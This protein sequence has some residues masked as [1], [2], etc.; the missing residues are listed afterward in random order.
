M[1]T[2]GRKLLAVFTAVL[3]GL[4]LVSCTSGAPSKNDIQLSEVM[5]KNN[6]TLA[7]NDNEYP[8][9]IELY[10]PTD[11]EISLEGYSLTDNAKKKG[12]FV[13]PDITMQPGEYFVVYA[14]GKDYVDVDKRIIHLPYSINSDREDVYLYN[15]KGKE[16][17]H[18]AL[19]NLK[20]NM[21]CGL[22]EKG[23]TVY[24]QTPTPGAANSETYTPPQAGSNTPASDIKVYINEYST[25]S[26]VTLADEDGEFV[27]WVELYNYGDSPVNLSGCTLSDDTGKTDKWFFPAVTIPAGGYQVVYLSGKTKMYTE[28]GELHADFSLTGKESIIALYGGDGKEVDSCPVYELTSNLTYGRT[29]ADPERLQ[30]FAKATPGAANTLPGFDEIDSARYPKN[31]DVI[32]S[33]V[34]AVNTSGP[35]ASDKQ[36]YDYIELHNPTDKPVSLNGYRLSDKQDPSQWLALPDITLEPGAYQVI[37]CADAG[38]YNAQTKEIFLKLGL[39]RYGEH[40]YLTDSQGVV[41]DSFQSGRLEDTYSCGRVSDTDPTVYFFTTMTPGQANPTAGLKGP[42]PTPVFSVSTGYVSSGTQVSI[43]CPGAVIRYTTDGSTPTADSPV[44]NGPLTVSENITIRARAYMDGRLPS[45]DSS[46]SYLIGRKHDMPVIF[47]STDPDNLFD[48]NTG[49][50]A[51]GPGKSDTFPFTGANYWKDWERPVHFE[52]MDEKGNAQLSFNAGIKVFGQYSR[53]LD[54]KSVSIN[55]RDK[56]GPKEICYPFFRDGE[57]NV[58]SSLVLRDS[59]QDNTSAH[60]RDAFCAMAVKGQMDIDIMDYRP[61]VVYINGEYYG[62]YD[63]REKIDEDYTGNHYGTDEEQLDMIKGNS[64][65]MSGS[66]D[67]Y[68]QLLD[69]V[70]NHDLR[71]EENYRYICSVVD[72]DELTN[73]WI[74]ESFFNNTDTGN[75]KFYK[76]KGEGH[77]WRWVLFDLDWALSPS[78]Y[79]WNMVEEIVHPKGHGVGKAF[80]SSL[81]R[82]LMANTTYREKF[83]STYGEYLRTVFDTDRLLNLYDSMIAELETEMPYH[84]ERWAKANNAAGGAAIAP[85]SLESWKANVATLRTLISKKN[86]LTRQAVIDTFTKSSYTKAYHMSEAAVVA[87]L[88]GTN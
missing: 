19:Q 48:Y 21:T 27:S 5:A 11:K 62:I 72:V 24:Y 44:Y 66:M 2:I 14:S 34:A 77:K 3:L 53:A 67:E 32:V 60:I 36:R 4:G 52:Y 12:K 83:I 46:G 56:Y 88:D 30:F 6:G 42:S 84:M 85:R 1:R 69:Y 35:T 59:G 80:D 51:D 39:N 26:T 86:A 75:I 57:V 41:V 63:L 23:N 9:W 38:K 74:T 33:E 50:F 61:V 82:G 81:M 70:K 54:Q 18:I 29:A 73:W 37:Y 49:I 68:R 10:N 64:N 87:L 76:E 55:L 13:F 22:D 47:L 79:D 58:F 25:N 40:I 31:K 43:D 28:G 65:I 78:T 15:S 20:E 16:L 17:G 8:D 7:D 45:E 71:Q